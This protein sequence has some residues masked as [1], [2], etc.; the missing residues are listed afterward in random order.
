MGYVDTGSVGSRNHLLD[1][2]MST[3]EQAFVT[4]AS[5]IDC[6]ELVTPYLAALESG[7]P[8]KSRLRYYHVF[9]PS[10][11]YLDPD[12]QDSTD[13]RQW[14]VMSLLMAAAMVR[15]GGL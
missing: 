7:V 2:K 10:T 1:D 4:A 11:A 9:I 14:K 12:L 3:A 15:Q 8:P 13:L 6:G 5:M